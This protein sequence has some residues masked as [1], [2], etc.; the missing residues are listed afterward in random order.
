[1]L[2]RKLLG[3]SSYSYTELPQGQLVVL[4][5][6]GLSGDRGCPERWV[7][8]QLEGERM[9]SVTLQS[10]DGIGRPSSDSRA[11]RLSPVQASLSEV[12]RAK[13][14]MKQL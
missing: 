4:I 11:M 12:S 2:L 10:S 14:A 3:S 1:M 8:A 13:V 7:Q 6:S 9:R 5:Q